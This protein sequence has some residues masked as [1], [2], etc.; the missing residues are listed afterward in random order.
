MFPVR[1]I[2]DELH[3]FASVVGDVL[4]G[5][6]AVESFIRAGPHDLGHDGRLRDLY[7]FPAIP[8][9]GV[10]IAFSLESGWH[11]EDA[12]IILQLAN[13]S[14]TGLSLLA[15]FRALPP[16]AAPSAAQRAVQ[17]RAVSKAERM[18]SLMQVRRDE[19]SSRGVR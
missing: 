2:P 1:R 9:G 11:P 7:P 19:L 16:R 6:P 18:W 13:Q 12:A 4:G 5:L 3:V 10:G 15:G 14:P 8:A 17:Q